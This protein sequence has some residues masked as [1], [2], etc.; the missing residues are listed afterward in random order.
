MVSSNIAR[1]LQMN[2]A[3]IGVEQFVSEISKTFMLCDP[4]HGFLKACTKHTQL[5]SNITSTLELINN[6]HINMDNLCTQQPLQKQ[7]KTQKKRK[8][9]KKKIIYFFKEIGL[10]ACNTRIITI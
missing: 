2:T 10:E 3:H 5:W 9:K 1:K 4:N 8:K 6:P 7:S